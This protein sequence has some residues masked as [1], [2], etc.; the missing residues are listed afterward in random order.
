MLESDAPHSIAPE[1]R[2]RGLSVRAALVLLLSLPALLALAAQ[3]GVAVVVS[4]AR[5]AELSRVAQRWPGLR[6]AA[7]QVQAEQQALSSTMLALTLLGLLGALLVGWFVAASL[8]RRLKRLEDAVQRIAAGDMVSPIEQ[9]DDDVELS[10]LVQDL[11]RMQQ[12]LRE[13]VDSEVVNVEAEKALELSATIRRLFLPP[14]NDFEVGTARGAAFYQ[15][16]SRCGGD[17][18]HHHVDASG[19]ICLFVGDVTGHGAGSA[20]VTA[21][22]SSQLKRRLRRAEGTEVEPLMREVNESFVDLCGDDYR[23]TMAVIEIH[24]ASRRLKLWSAGAPPLAISSDQG[25]VRVMAAPGTPLGS[26]ELRIG[27][28]EGEL[29]AHERLHIFTDGIL[30]AAR[31]DGR[32]VGLRRLCKFIKESHPLPLTQGRGRVLQRL[33]QYV[34]DTPADDDWTL[35]S[36]EV[37]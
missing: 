13:R 22:L 31:E 23:M 5:Q 37:A 36:L 15:P 8:A 26:A 12:S 28:A 18:W 14:D 19:R 34:G 6:D 25:D 33:G 21:A 7:L 20:V 32:E 29:E 27:V 1:S 4:Q 10:P 30:E 9:P 35:V 2:A 11:C 3:G 16:A 17:W 24:P